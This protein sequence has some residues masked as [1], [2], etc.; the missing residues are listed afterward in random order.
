VDLAVVHSPTE[1]DLARDLGARA[2]RTVELPPFGPAAD[3]PARTSSGG[4][5]LLFFGFLRPYK[6]VE[7][8]LRALAKVPDARLVI[9]GESWDGDASSTALVTELGLRDR[10]ELRLRYLPE[11][12]LE[13]L[14]GS[15]DALVIPYLSGTGTQHVR[16]AQRHGLPVVAT[17]ISSIPDQVHDG[18]DGFLVDPGDVDG[19][20]EALR[21]LYEPGTLE[22]LRAAV[23]PPDDEVLWGPY[24]A[25]FTDIPA[26][27]RPGG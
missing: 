18:E 5:G 1:A 7:V 6:G 9:A 19:L 25:V 20:A 23:R 2:T 24:L 14:L 27:A 11:A 4:G 17:R 21:R 15:A 26:P 12:E 16:V 22:R 13:G 10:V 8:L 3:R